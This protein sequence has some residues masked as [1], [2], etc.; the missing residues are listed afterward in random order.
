[1]LPLLGPVLLPALLVT[2]LAAGP[3]T[4]PGA[5][6]PRGPAPPASPQDTAAAWVPPLDGDLRVTARFDRPAQDWLP[7]HRGVDLSASPGDAV[8]AAGAGVV[9]WAAPVVDREVVVVL[10]ADGRRTTYEPVDAAVGAGD[11]VEAGDLIGHVGAGGGHCGGI[12]ACLH[13]GLRLGDAYLDPLLLLGLGRP[14][15]L[16]LG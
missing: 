7:G 12:P 10:H 13:W 9:T 1:M 8:R 6:P 4:P 2:A 15:L 3:V 16:P 5:V 14:V 11:A